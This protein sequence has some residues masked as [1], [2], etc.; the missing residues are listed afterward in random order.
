MTQRQR[1]DRKFAKAP[2]IENMCTRH[3]FTP[4]IARLLYKPLDVFRNWTVA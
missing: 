2:G 4:Q 3:F 1:I